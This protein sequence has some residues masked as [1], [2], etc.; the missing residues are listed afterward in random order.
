MVVLAVRPWTALF[1][2]SFRRLLSCKILLNPFLLGSR[3]PTY[4]CGSKQE[5]SLVNMTC[6]RQINISICLGW[7][8]LWF[9]LFVVMLFLLGFFFFFSSFWKLQ[10][11]LVLFPDFVYDCINQLRLLK[12]HYLNVLLLFSKENCYGAYCYFQDVIN[13]SRG[14]LLPLTLTVGRGTGWNL[15]FCKPSL[16]RFTEILKINS[17]YCIFKNHYFNSSLFSSSEKTIFLWRC[18]VQVGIVSTPT[19]WHCIYPNHYIF[20]GCLLWT[21]CFKIAVGLIFSVKKFLNSYRFT[22]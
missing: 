10:I 6:V 17:F 22:V 14:Y 20:I 19:T 2:F 4:C 16:G 5:C 13:R 8:F 11:L 3:G 12:K 15:P 21:L 9:F 18:L 1:L 7:L